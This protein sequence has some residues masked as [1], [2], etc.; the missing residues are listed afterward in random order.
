M[1]SA[2]ESNKVWATKRIKE[3][4]RAR[5]TSKEFEALLDPA[6]LKK[7]TGAKYRYTYPVL[8]EISTDIDG[9]RYYSEEY[10]FY[11]HKYRLC[12]DWYLPNVTVK[13]TRTPFAEWVVKICGA[14]E[15]N[16]I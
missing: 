11:G 13:D 8:A 7:A 2:T 9:A 6:K 1:T 3:L 12:N 16:Q 10:T 4:Q 15:R 5:M 14:A